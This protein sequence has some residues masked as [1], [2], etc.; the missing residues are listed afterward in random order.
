VILFTFSV[1]RLDSPDLLSGSP[2]SYDRLKP[3]VVQSIQ[4]SGDLLRTFD[5]RREENQ[6]SPEK[7]IL[8]INLQQL[9]YKGMLLPLQRLAHE[10]SEETLA[11]ELMDLDDK[12]RAYSNKLSIITAKERLQ[13]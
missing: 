2:S 4:E 12:F 10:L 1:L 5:K 3:V 6:S 9:C 13:V 7:W 11:A 8:K